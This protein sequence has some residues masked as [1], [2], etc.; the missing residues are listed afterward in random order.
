MVNR[1]FIT[2]KSAPPVFL[3]PRV[4]WGIKLGSPNRLPPGGVVVQPPERYIEER[5]STFN[6]EICRWPQQP[7]YLHRKL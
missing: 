7:P 1:L 5:A 3:R 2:L 4:A 6:E